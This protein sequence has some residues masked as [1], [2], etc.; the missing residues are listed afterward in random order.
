MKGE[1]M[2]GKVEGYALWIAVV[3]A[4]GLS[5][6]S[7]VRQQKTTAT[8]LGFVNTAR[9]MTGFKVS[10]QVQKELEAKDKVWRDKLKVL[11]DSLKVFMDKMG[12]DYD[13]LNMAG[14][15]AMQD[16]LSARNQ[17]INNFTR[18]NS[19]QMQK[20][21]QEKMASVYDK[22]N[23]YV[24]EFGDKNGYDILLGT[25]QGGN[26]IYGENKSTDVTQQVLDG[27]NSRYE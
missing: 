25:V 14:K 19:E 9:I 7:L 24:K 4:L 3:L 6:F 21:S 17:Q 13:K 2:K 18:Y 23:A 1:W 11:E 10:H 8:K 26:I 15:K 5:V 22:I 16:E 12:S 20:A 27:L